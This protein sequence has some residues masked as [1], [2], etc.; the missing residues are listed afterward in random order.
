[1]CSEGSPEID[2]TF[3]GNRPQLLQ[4]S[5]TRHAPPTL[6]AAWASNLPVPG[7]IASCSDQ[8]VPHHHRVSS[9]AYL[10]CA[11]ILLFFFL[12]CFSTTS[13]LLLVETI[14]SEFLELSHEHFQ[15]CSVL[16]MHSG[17][18]KGV[19]S[20]MVPPTQNSTVFDWWSSQANSLSGFGGGTVSVWWSS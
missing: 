19:I 2:L 16:L 12:F 20:I 7:G 14:I 4:D 18:G 11:H 6:V 3:R 17:T 10:H 8:A 5:W 9:S 15:E 1:M 13:L